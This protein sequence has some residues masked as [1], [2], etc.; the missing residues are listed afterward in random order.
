MKIDPMKAKRSEL[1]HA[2][3]LVSALVQLPYE[4]EIA[5][6]EKEILALKLDALNV[7]LDRIRGATGVA[8]GYS[9][10]W[11]AIHLAFSDSEDRRL[12][13]TTGKSNLPTPKAW[14]S[15][16]LMPRLL[17]YLHES[18]A[19]GLPVHEIMRTFKQSMQQ[20]L[21]GADAA[22]SSNG[23]L[24]F[25]TNAAFAA[26]KL[27]QM[28]LLLNTPHERF[29]TW[30]LS[31]GGILAA[32]AI[33]RAMN[34]LPLNK[35]WQSSHDRGALTLLSWLHHT[36]HADFAQLSQDLEELVM[37]AA[38]ETWSPKHATAFFAD[39]INALAASVGRPVFGQS[40]PSLLALKKSLENLAANP[41]AIHLAQV[42]AGFNAG[43]RM[44]DSC[45]YL[46]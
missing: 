22:T 29:H 28:G 36:W 39:W 26:S 13:F 7:V 9:H 18:E 23:V 40:P 33:I 25:H 46:K 42:W 3:D 12:I 32:K 20:R 44:P 37:K 2:K 16:A 30:R 15:E 17:L 11:P 24:R 6:S 5:R 19:A 1:E 38:Q 27:R 8:K 45:V 41:N 31:L 43:R 4:A 14:S 10:T 35:E 34:N 21:A